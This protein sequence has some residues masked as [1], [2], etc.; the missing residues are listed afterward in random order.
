MGTLVAKAYPTALFAN[1]ADHTYVECQGGGKAWGC[2]GGKTGGRALAQGPGSTKR[3]DCIAR[4]DERA[5]ITCYLVN[6][7][8]HQA[9]NRILVTAGLTVRGAR[10]Y[11]IS[12]ALFGIYGRVGF[13][14]CKAPFNQCRG[15][16]GD[17]AACAPAAPAVRESQA[18]SREQAEDMQGPL[19][20]YEGARDLLRGDTE[21]FQTVAE[22]H[23][24]LFMEMARSRLGDDGRERFGGPL[25]EVRRDAESR[26]LELQRTFAEGEL[27]PPEY[28]HQFD[29]LTIAFQENVAQSVHGNVYVA[30][31]DEEPGDWIKLSDPRIIEAEYGFQVRE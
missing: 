14:P 25:E 13:W 23:V 24:A 6:G 31:L 3:A 17:L 1:R 5:G 11:S 20:M 16:S 28:V 12:R 7:V 8:C 30:L 9:A 18:D 27:T 26:I 19:E 15:V 2:W 29:D 22:F 21:D 4:P 10:G